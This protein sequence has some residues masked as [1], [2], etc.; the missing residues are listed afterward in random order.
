[1]RRQFAAQLGRGLQAC[2]EG[3]LLGGVEVAVQMAVQQ[4]LLVGGHARASEIRRCTQSLRIS[5]IRWRSELTAARLWPLRSAIDGRGEA[6]LVAPGQ[7]LAGA[8]LDLPQAAAQRLLARVGVDP[9]DRVEG[10]LDAVE[11][12][13]VDGDAGAA[14]EMLA[15]LVAGDGAGPGDEVRAVLELGGLLDRDD[16]DLLEEVLGDVGVGDDAVEIGEQTVAV[17]DDQL[18]DLRRVAQ[19]PSLGA[20]FKN[21]PREG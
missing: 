9:A 8:V 1:V 18:G 17:L 13:V 10:G 19:C 5:R 7:H 21:A 14:A 20:L 3:G 15:E 4:I 2:E 6:L 11:E 16:A 12:G